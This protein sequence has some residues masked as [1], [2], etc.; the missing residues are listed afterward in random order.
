MHEQQ[1]AV[2][3]NLKKIERRLKMLSEH[4]HHADIYFQHRALYKEYMQQNPK[5]QE[6][7]YQNH[8]AGLVLYESAEQY[9]KKVMNGRT[10]IPTKAWK[11]EAA[12]LASEKKKL[13]PVYFQMKEEVRD[14]EVIQRCIEQSVRGKELAPK[15]QKDIYI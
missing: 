9:L 10:T 6:A 12:S 8:R 5:K 4:I 7:F 1:N 13:Y 15:I 2:T 14:A 3:S 11:A